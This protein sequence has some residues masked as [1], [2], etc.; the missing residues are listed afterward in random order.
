MNNLVGTSKDRAF[1]SSL[2]A[3]YARSRPICLLQWDT[4][5]CRARLF[6]DRSLAVTAAT[7]VRQRKPGL[8]RLL[9]LNVGLRFDCVGLAESQRLVVHR[10]LDLPQQLLNCL[11]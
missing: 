4:S 6:L 5:H 9:Q 8:D 3:M 10:L 7:P 11:R 2:A 1:R